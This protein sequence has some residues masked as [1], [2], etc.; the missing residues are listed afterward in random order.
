MFSKRIDVPFTRVVMSNDEAR[1]K[2]DEA[3]AQYGG[4]SGLYTMTEG[5]M[6]EKGRPVIVRTITFLNRPQEE[7]KKGGS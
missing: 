5:K 3:L 2:I 4:I 6:S 7:E 1:D